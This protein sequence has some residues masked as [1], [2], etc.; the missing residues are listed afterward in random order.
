MEAATLELS[1]GTLV[2]ETFG[3]SDAADVY[4]L[5]HGFAG[6]RL[7]WLGL[8]PRLGERHFAIVPDLPAHGDTTLEENDVERL[9]LVVP[10]L[11]DALAV[12]PERLH[13]VGISMG[14]I[15]ATRLAQALCVEGRLPRSLTLV[16]STGLGLEIN[17]PVLSGFAGAPSAG[18]FS[19]LLRQLA[20]H[21]PD[22]TEAQK[23][24]AVGRLALRRVAGLADSLFGPGGQRLDIVDALGRL[25]AGGL[26][27]RLLFGRDDAIVPWQ[28]ALNAPPQVALHY[29]RDAGHMV[30]WDVP[31]ELLAVIAG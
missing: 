13:I 4:L 17:V 18:A 23:A 7:S 3:Q 24:F 19:H 27:V 20:N 2:Y 11:L 31:D 12:A 29:F 14:G 6:D 21:V 16:S 30:H 15:V 1:G 25:V 9:H 28:H 10:P 5:I 8:G 22:L 26:P